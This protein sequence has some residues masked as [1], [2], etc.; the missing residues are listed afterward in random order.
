MSDRISVVP[1][2]PSRHVIRV[3]EVTEGREQFVALDSL[4]EAERPLEAKYEAEELNAIRSELAQLRA[5]PALPPNL[6]SLVIKLID[7][8]TPPPTLAKETAAVLTDLTNAILAI[9]KSQ[10]A[11]DSRLSVLE[12]SI[13]AVGEKLGV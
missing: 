12:R 2:D 10:A 1:F 8:Y 6:D 7:Q 11:F 3:R 13:V 4:V 5:A 9:K